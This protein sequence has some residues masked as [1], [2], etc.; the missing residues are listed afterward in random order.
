MKEPW[1]SRS[2]WKSAL[3]FALVG[4]LVGLAIVLGLAVANVA[5]L[6][7]LGHASEIA[8]PD[9][10]AAVILLKVLPFILV[11]FAAAF[12]VGAPGAFVA[13]AAMQWMR[14]RCFGTIWIVGANALIGFAVS[15]LTFS[16]FN[17]YVLPHPHLDP[18][19][20]FEPSMAVAIGVVGAL[21]AI[22]C[23]LVKSRQIADTVCGGPP[24]PSD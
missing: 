9:G 1:V 2:V 13:G 4:P 5:R 14:E 6:M 21:S 11:L 18:A 19:P 22:I 23:T 12:V 10:S 16:G 15:Y 20:A 17:E 24:V 3:Q 7:I 8:P